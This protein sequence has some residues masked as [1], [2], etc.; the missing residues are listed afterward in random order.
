[1]K[2]TTWEQI[3][4]A[5]AA[6]GTMDIKGKDYA[7]VNQRVK[8]FRM[9]YPTGL[10][11]TEMVSNENGTCLFRATVAYY[12][13][14]GEA[15]TIATGTAQ[16]VQSASYINKTSYIENCE[17]S[18]VGRALG[19]AGFG[20][21]T[22]ICSA[23]ELQNALEQQAQN[24]PAPQYSKPQPPT[25]VFATPI[26]E[27]ADLPVPKD[28]PEE[29]QYRILCLRKI[30][31]DKLNKSC[32]RKYGTDFK[33]TSVT[34]LKEVLPDEMLNGMDDITKED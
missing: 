31:L 14:K 1:M 6:I 12:N 32:L 18:A 17:T 34:Q 5:N 20:I 10:I 23:E 7:E 15:V 27:V 13:D 19:L 21:D 26:V 4:A 3:A 9:V 24:K 11:L 29:A 30:K 28:T 16:E 33:H 8:A 25:E 22:S 2:E